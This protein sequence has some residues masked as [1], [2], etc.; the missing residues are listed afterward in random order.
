MA[1]TQYQV[2]ALEAALASGELRVEYDGKKVEYRSIPEL[3]QA[4]AYARSQMATAS[5][6]ARVMMQP[7]TFRRD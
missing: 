3:Q 6:T 5:G 1:I 2:D 7:T 4:L